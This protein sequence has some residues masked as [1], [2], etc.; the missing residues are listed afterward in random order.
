MPSAAPLVAVDV[1]NS[2]IK[3]GRF[4]AP[5]APGALPAPDA[6]LDLA[7][8]WRED[9]LLVLAA[10][11]PSA[12]WLVGSVNRPAAAR[13]IESVRAIQPRGVV[14]LLALAELPI[15]VRVPRPERVGIDRLL[16]AVAANH[17]RDAGRPAVVVD[18]GTAITVDL[19]G[20]D[21]AFAGGAI[22]PGIALAARALHEHTDL[23]PYI[24]MAELAA[25]E[26]PLGTDTES[27][28]R[29]GL[30]WGAIGGARELIARLEEQAG[31]DAQV[32]LTGG[33]ASSVAGLLRPDARFEPHLVLAGIALAARGMGAAT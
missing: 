5:I 26:P 11:Y 19:V 20:G 4:A 17:V 13:L 15:A 10:E 6:T 23:L 32:F 16:G 7:R 1:G 30:F 24:D 2:R 22:L 3:L 21:G 28:I 31:G 9:D 18:L 33:A 25:R 29:S 8:D 14:R 12:L 27:A